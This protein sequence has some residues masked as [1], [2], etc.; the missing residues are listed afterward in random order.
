MREILTALNVEAGTTGSMV[1]TLDG[2]MVAAA[3]DDHYEEDSM[4]AFAASL[5]LTV[6]KNLSALNASSSF[7]SV[8]LSA[9]DG[10]LSFFDMSNSYLV[11]VSDPS[12][13]LDC[14]SKPIQ[15]A[16][17]KIVSRRMV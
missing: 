11:L 13:E 7:R 5:L 15:N 2:I 17:H 9:T 4:A 14:E 10:K 6:K 1:I 8:T 16:I 12:T 3:L